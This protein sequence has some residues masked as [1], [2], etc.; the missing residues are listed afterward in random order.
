MRIQYL[1][2]ESLVIDHWHSAYGFGKGVLRIAG[3][4]RI[5]D[6]SMLRADADAK[7]ITDDRE[8]VCRVLGIPYPDRQVAKD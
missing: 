5:V 8:Q 2:R 1:H 4:G 6:A 3:T 7:I